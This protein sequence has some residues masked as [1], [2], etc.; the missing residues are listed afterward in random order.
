MAISIPFDTIRLTEGLCDYAT[1]TGAS[2]APRA[3]GYGYENI[4]LNNMDY[5]FGMNF[6][7][8]YGLSTDIKDS[9][10]HAEVDFLLPDATE[11]LFDGQLELRKDATYSRCTFSVFPTPLMMSL[12]GT[13]KCRFRL[14]DS[15]DTLL[16]SGAFNYTIINDGIVKYC[17]KLD[18]WKHGIPPRIHVSQFDTDFSMEFMIYSSRGEASFVNSSERVPYD[19]EL[20]ATLPDGSELNIHGS[21]LE[22]ELRTFYRKNKGKTQN[23]N[24]P[25]EYVYIVKFKPTAELTAQIGE[26]PF[27]V[28]LR[29]ISSFNTINGK[30][31]YT[32]KELRTSNAELIVEAKPE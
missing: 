9:I 13:V 31:S 29:E 30:Y 20:R 18:L 8:Y 3:D 28:I 17:R 25:R 11:H 26:I 4:K 19:T 2:R 5:R 14:L 32:G 23:A 27:E 21:L 12:F 7:T 1:G 10:D 22:R 24:N 15:T 16:A 6:S